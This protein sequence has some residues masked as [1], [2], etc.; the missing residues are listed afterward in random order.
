M[1]PTELGRAQIQRNGETR[2]RQRQ[3]TSVDWAA[4][5]P[6]QTKEEQQGNQVTIVD[7]HEWVIERRRNKR[8]REEVEK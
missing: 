4:C 2:K 5:W 7:D 8:E 1:E 3:R 6:R